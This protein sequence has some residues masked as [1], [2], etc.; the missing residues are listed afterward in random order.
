MLTFTTTFTREMEKG[1]VGGLRTLSCS[2]FAILLSKVIY[3]TI[4]LTLVL[5]VMLPLSIVFLNVQ[6][7]LNLLNLVPVTLLGILDISFV[8]AFVA[9]LVM[10]SEGKTL[11]LAFLLFPVSIPVL[12]P[13]LLATQKILLESSLIEVVGEIRILLAFLVLILFF[14]ILTFSLVLED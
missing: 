4:L 12:I 10:Y 11:L 1:T 6:S 3:S 14:S 13:S 2:S 8:G 5:L 7:S 9:S